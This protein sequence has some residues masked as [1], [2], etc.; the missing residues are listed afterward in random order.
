MR[1]STAEQTLDLQR[2]A[3]KRAGCERLYEDVASGAVKDLAGLARALDHARDGD[4]IVVWKLDRLGS[5]LAHVVQLVSEL[6]T[7]ASI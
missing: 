7:V 6:R 1:V 5:S 3:L 2:D 4:T